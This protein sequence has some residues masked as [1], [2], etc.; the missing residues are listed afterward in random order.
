MNEGALVLTSDGTIIYSNQRFADMLDVPLGQVI[1]S[2]IHRFARESDLEALDELLEE[3]K[4]FEAKRDIELR[5]GSDG[6]LV[7]VQIS[8]GNMHF[9]NEEG[10]A[11]VVTDITERLR[12]ETAL[13]AANKE[14]EAFS[15]SVSHDLRTPLRAIDG[16]SRELLA[17]YDDKL[18]EQGKDYLRRVR[19]AA[20]RM[21]HL[22]DDIVVM[23]QATRAEMHRQEVDLSGL[24][25]QV[26]AELRKT[27]PDRSV[28]VEIVQGLHA[29]GDSHLLRLVLENLL[30]NA[31]KFTARRD[32]ARIELGS[33]EQNAERVYYVKDNGIGFDMRHVGKLFE[34][35]Q[36]L[37]KERDFPGSG[38]GLA[39]VDRIV[40]RHGGRIW[41]EGTVG[42]GAT[43]YFTLVE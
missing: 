9:G 22:I 6:A 1:G 10:M 11:T 29:N 23:S 40:R 39:I 14:L 12:K 21:G 18:D 42:A 7:S 24:A 25:R 5:K 34:P 20:Q 38:I 41:A 2:R 13:E 16:F 36:R 28:Q 8:V 30:G 33:I 31:W 4:H 43:F 35:F 19:V 26:T 32:D 17:D 37:H 27:Q 15:Y 3:G